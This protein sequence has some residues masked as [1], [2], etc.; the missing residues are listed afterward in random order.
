MNIFTER[1]V[2]KLVEVIK[3]L[4]VA[5]TSLGVS[6]NQRTTRAQHSTQRMCIDNANA[7]D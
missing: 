2:L 1:G 7:I 6:S 5:I 4:Q 3:R